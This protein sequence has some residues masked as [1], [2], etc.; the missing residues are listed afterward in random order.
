MPADS[1]STLVT[2]PPSAFEQEVRRIAASPLRL[3]HPR[4]EFKA[5]GS[6]VLRCD[7][8]R[9]PKDYCICQ[10]RTEVASNAVFWVL[11]HTEEVNK[12]TNTARLIGDTLPETRVFPWFRM[13]PPEELLALLADPTYQPFIIFPDDQ[14]DYLHRVVE[15]EPARQGQESRR[16]AFILLDG[17]WR[18]ARRMFR[19]SPWLDHLPVLPLRTSQ[20]TDYRLRKPA[21]EQHLCTAEVGIEL[22]KLAGDTHA[23]G[24]LQQY[25]TVFN[26]GYGAARHQRPTEELTDAM[27]WL[28]DYQQP[29][30]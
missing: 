11:M 27:Q 13:Q 19:K 1:P 16:P 6:F 29:Q 14:P 30:D 26:Q 2:K 17:T 3:T 12:P 23:A 22:L 7:G 5:R 18:Q 8:C 25:F 4:R 24:V 21:S 9:M 28:L 20:K 15:F 10:Y